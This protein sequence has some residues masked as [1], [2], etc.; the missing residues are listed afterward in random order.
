M[1]EKHRP[2]G[3]VENAD[4]LNTLDIA[5]FFFSNFYKSDFSTFI[6]SQIRKLGLQKLRV[7]QTSVLSIFT[8]SQIR[9][10]RFQKSEIYK[11]PSFP[12]LPIVKYQ[13]LDFKNRDLQTSVFPIFA[14]SQIRKLGCLKSEISKHPTFRPENTLKRVS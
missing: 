7:F 9:K 14:Y 5:D 3:Q 13:N 10:F 4:V 11:N 8:Y 12:Y 6:Y 1:Q 2:N